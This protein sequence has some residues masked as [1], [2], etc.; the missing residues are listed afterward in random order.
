MN[1]SLMNQIRIC[2]DENT[3]GTLW[4]YHIVHGESIEYQDKGDN[5]PDFM[6]DDV[7]RGRKSRFFG[8][9]SSSKLRKYD[10]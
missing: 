2:R 5:R 7:K 8:G 4:S 10:Y 3:Y 6:S 9:T 1:I